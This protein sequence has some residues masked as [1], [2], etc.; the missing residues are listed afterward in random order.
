V[1]ELT[2]PTLDITD[3]RSYWGLL[4]TLPDAM[5]RLVLHDDPT[6][7][8]AYWQTRTKQTLAGATARANALRVIADDI[9]VNGYDPNRWRTDPRHFQGVPD[10]FGP[11][12][13]VR[14]GKTIFPRDGSHRASILKALD[15]VVLAY[16]WKEQ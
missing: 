5:A 9:R 3:S 4:G 6:P 16:V 2:L 15:R 7:Y 8:I 14:S 1:A 10:G 12:T 11:I 13:V